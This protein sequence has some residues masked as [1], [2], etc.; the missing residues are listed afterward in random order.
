MAYNAHR[1]GTDSHNKFTDFGAPLYPSPAEPTSNVTWNVD[2]VVKAFLQAG[3]PAQRLVLGVSGYGRSYAGVADI[4]HGLYQT[5]SGAGPGDAGGAS[6]ALT[7]NEIAN[8]YLF[9]SDYSW[10]LDKITSSAYLYSPTQHVWISYEDPTPVVTKSVYAIQ[11]RLA[12]LMLWDVSADTPSGASTSPVSSLVDTMWEL[13][14]VGLLN[15]YK[16]ILSEYSSSAPALCSHSGC[17]L[18]AWT[19]S[20]NERL[21]VMYS[22][23][24]GATFEGKVTSPEIS[25]VGPALASHNRLNIKTPPQHNL[26]IAWP[27][28]ASVIID[29]EGG[30]GTNIP[31]VLNVARIPLSANTSGTFGGIEHLANKNVLTDTSSTALALASLGGRL[32][33]AW[34][35]LDN[36]ELN[37]MFSSDDGATF[38]GKTVLASALEGSDVGPALASHNGN[39]FMAWKASQTGN[40]N[41]AQVL[42]SIDSSGT[43]QGIE[44]LI[45][46]TTLA[47]TSSAAPALCSHNGRLFLAWKG[48]GN[49]TDLYVMLSIDNGATFGL[50]TSFGNSDAAPAL[51]SHD[52]TLFVAWSGAGS[53]DSLNVGVLSYA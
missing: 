19:E 42:F 4:N 48:P 22:T 2:S 12:G 20:S 38:E 24:N 18:L 17:L 39:L 51:A 23:D 27:G 9:S 3:L 53:D 25:N 10:F 36:D 45:G 29:T 47:E 46:Q 5:Y 8:Q 11:A 44:G 26:R 30:P 49:A 43:F 21:S 41:V 7:Y 6:G 14:A 37:I 40:L 50:K 1:A 32:F 16:L 15:D 35:S 34:R 31:N 33:L 13:M 28:A 52:G